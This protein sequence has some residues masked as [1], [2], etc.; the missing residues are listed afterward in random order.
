MNAWKMVSKVIVIRRVLA[1]WVVWRS[2]V[3]DLPKK[4]NQEVSSCRAFS[5]TLPKVSFA[6]SNTPCDGDAADV[7][8]EVNP[9]SDTVSFPTV[10]L[11]TAD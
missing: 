10:V 6:C 7:N 11:T 2:H 3:E 4:F 9:S 8:H 5:N 1:V